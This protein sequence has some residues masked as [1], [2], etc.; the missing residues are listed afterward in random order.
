MRYNI[1][2]MRYNMQYMRYNIWETYGKYMGQNEPWLNLPH[3]KWLN[4]PQG[5][6]LKK[7]S[8]GCST[9][10]SNCLSFFRVV[11]LPLGK[12]LLPIYFMASEIFKPNLAHKVKTQKLLFY[13]KFNIFELTFLPCTC[14]K[15]QSAQNGCQQSCDLCEGNQLL[16]WK[17]FWKTV[18]GSLCPL[19]H[20]TSPSL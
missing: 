16:I 15:H 18:G 4:L 9:W 17:G 13:E 6:L 12:T 19:A 14:C 2:N 20:L 11:E 10:R 1:W 7:T 8:V 5:V 3:L